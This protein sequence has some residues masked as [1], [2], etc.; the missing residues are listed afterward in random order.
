MQSAAIIVACGGGIVPVIGWQALRSAAD[1]FYFALI[2]GIFIRA[3]RVFP[4][5][6]IRLAR[7]LAIIGG[8][9]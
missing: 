5:P 3:S 9:L 4:P 8:K 7:N 2:A 1:L 6:Q